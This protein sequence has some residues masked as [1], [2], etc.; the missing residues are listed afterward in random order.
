MPRYPTTHAYSVPSE[1]LP[2]RA[3]VAALLRVGD[4]DMFVACERSSGE[5]W[6]TVQ[7]GVEPGDATMEDALLREVNEEL[8]IALPDLRIEVRS[9]VWRRYRFPPNMLARAHNRHQGQ[10]QLWFVARIASLDCIRLDKSGGEFRAV[11][12]V[13]AAE[14]VQLYVHWKRAVVADFCRELGLLPAV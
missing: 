7:G 6:Q 8:G 9:P 12:S 3:N 5:G 14:L 1:K 2:Y 10:E 4:G 11:K 13:S